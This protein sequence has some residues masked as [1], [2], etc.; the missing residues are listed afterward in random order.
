[1]HCQFKRCFTFLL[2]VLVL[3]ACSEKAPTPTLVEVVVD[4]VRVHP[5]KPNSSFVGRLKAQDDVNIQAQVSGYLQSR[6]FTEGE[7]VEKGDLLYVIDPAQYEARLASA[8][9]TL[10]KAN[11]V[12]EVADRNYN[13]GSE[14]APKGA[15]SI[16]ELDT[17]LAKKLEADADLQAARAGLKSAEVDLSYTTIHAPITGRIG[18]SEF[19][20]GDLISPESGA[21]TSLVSIDPIMAKFQISEAVYLISEHRRQLRIKEAGGAELNDGKLP[22]LTVRLEMADREIYPLAG[23]LDY[24]SNRIDEATGTIEARAVFSNPEGLLRPGQYVNVTLELPTFI[25][26]LMLPQAAVQADQQGSFVL[27]IGPDNKVLRR[28]VVLEDRVNDLVVVKQGVNE[29]DQLVV[30]GL[31]KIRPGQQVA[32]RSVGVQAETAAVGG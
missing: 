16:S 22:N 21:L 28:N 30:K 7:M 9:A 14:L 24:I 19:S 3:V 2:S 25:D 10:A 6:Y 31:Q 15:I 13:R 32:V 17:L 18:S 4:T 29:G 27:V 1:M 12:K 26:T 8:R 5:F 23:E 20:S 11:A